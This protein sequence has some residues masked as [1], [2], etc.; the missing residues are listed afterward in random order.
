MNLQD[1]LSP[2]LAKTVQARQ[3]DVIFLRYKED[4]E[5][6]LQSKAKNMNEIDESF[7]LICLPIIHFGNRYHKRKW[8]LIVLFELCVE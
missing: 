5:R 1:S 3:P 2:Q 4:I 8:C 6:L 7:K